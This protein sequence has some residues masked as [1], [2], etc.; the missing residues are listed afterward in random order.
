M[1]SLSHN[2]KTIKRTFRVNF[3]TLPLNEEGLQHYLHL[4]LLQQLCS[5]LESISETDALSRTETLKPETRLESHQPAHMH[6]HLIGCASF[7]CS[8]ESHSPLQVHIYQMQHHSHSLTQIAIL[9]LLL[10]AIH[11]SLSRHIVCPCDHPIRW[12]YQLAH[13]F[14]TGNHDQ[15]WSLSHI[16]HPRRMRLIVW[17]V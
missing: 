7:Q 5:T 2:T 11:Y 17:S 3:S 12:W 10:L 4:W 9:L 16:H 14:N 13:L 8:R 15:T 6:H 1:S